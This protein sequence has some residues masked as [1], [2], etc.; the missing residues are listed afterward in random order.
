MPASPEFVHEWFGQAGADAEL[1]ALGDQRGECGQYAGAQQ[2][3]GAGE[4][5]RSGSAREGA[6]VQ[7]GQGVEGRGGAGGEFV[8]ARSG[9]DPAR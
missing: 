2:L 1:H 3:G 7:G 8:G 5:D 6:A 9:F 4:V